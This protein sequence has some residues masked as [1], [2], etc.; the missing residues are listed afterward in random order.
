MYELIKSS[1]LFYVFA[2]AFLGMCLFS[3]IRAVFIGTKNME[4]MKIKTGL[5]CSISGVL[6]FL[7]AWVIVYR[8]LYPISLAYYE[9]NHDTVEEKA[10]VIDKIEQKVKDRIYLTIDNKEYTMVNGNDPS[11]ERIGRTIEE[12][13]T[14]IFKFGE[15]SKFIF[16]IQKSDKKH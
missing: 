12:G 3:F 15:K 11:A 1:F 10:G 4:N 6:V 2:A 5:R 16:E 7:W 14:V 9:Y 8:T 13:D